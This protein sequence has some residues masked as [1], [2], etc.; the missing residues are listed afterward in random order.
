MNRKPKVVI[1][2][3]VHESVLDLLSSHCELIP[4]QTARTLDRKEVVERSR[5]ADALMAF[6]PDCIDADF[7]SQTPRLKVVGAALKGYDNFDV[8]AFDEA[9]VWLTFVPDLL[10]V[11]TAELAIGLTVGLAR[12]LRAA[13][14]HVRSGAFRGWEPRFYGMG[15]AGAQIGVLGMGAIGRALAERL[16]GWGAQ[17]CY[18]DH[19]ALDRDSERR[20][21]LRRVALDTLLGHS[22]ILILALALTPDTVHVIDANSLER[23]KPGALLVNPCRGSIVDEVAVLGALE[24]GS[25][26]GYAADVFEMEDW[27]RPD[28]PDDIPPGLLAH[29]STLF[30]AHIGSAVTAVREAIELRAADNI[31]AVLRGQVPPDAANAPLR[32]RTQTC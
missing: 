15:I 32:V 3:R 27:A 28:R 7:L 23:M 4:N 17:L 18:A 12:H 22:D 8:N 5:D 9:G 30:S 10:T 13:D 11:P 26:G 14:A 6:M 20:L 1:T 31:V 21:G 19:V 29:P 25:L 16:Q 24:R 2:H